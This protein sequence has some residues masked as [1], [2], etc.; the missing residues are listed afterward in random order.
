[1]ADL[2]VRIARRENGRFVAASTAASP[3]FCFEADTEEGIT[4]IVNEAI[5]FYGVAKNALRERNQDR[6]E[7]SLTITRIRPTSRITVHGAAD[8]LPRL[9]IL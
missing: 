1:M 3:Y 7:T 5:A 6:H 9:G 4:Q 2:I 8:A